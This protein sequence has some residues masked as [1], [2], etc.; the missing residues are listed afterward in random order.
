MIAVKCSVQ[1]QLTTATVFCS[2]AQTDPCNLLSA[3][4]SIIGPENRSSPLLRAFPRV[5][6]IPEGH[7]RPMQVEPSLIRSWDWLLDASKCVCSTFIWQTKLL[8]QTSPTSR[9]RHVER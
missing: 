3:Q 2:R 9:I 5:P 7:D 4:D 1:G 8:M 6:P